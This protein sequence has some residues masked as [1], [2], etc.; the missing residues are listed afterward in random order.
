MQDFL[1]SLD[2]FG[3][4]LVGLVTHHMML[5]VRFRYVLAKCGLRAN[6]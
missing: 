1:D 3:A 5:W 4:G 2:Y 6:C